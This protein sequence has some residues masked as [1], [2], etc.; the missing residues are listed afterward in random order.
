MEE[1]QKNNSNNND[2]NKI[3]ILT[4]K[5]FGKTIKKQISSKNKRSFSVF[6]NLNIHFKEKENRELTNDNT[7]IKKNI[8]H[9]SDKAIFKQRLSV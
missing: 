7:T 4:T 6:N 3:N 1:N 5:T 2:N 8:N 9:F